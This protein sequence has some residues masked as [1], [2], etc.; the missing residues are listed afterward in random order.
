MLC[1]PQ[2]VFRSGINLGNY[3]ATLQTKFSNNMDLLT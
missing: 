3:N 1:D 2:R